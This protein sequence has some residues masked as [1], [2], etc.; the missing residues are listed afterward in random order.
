MRHDEAAEDED[1]VVRWTELR[2]N[3]VGTVRDAVCDRLAGLGLIALLDEAR[4]MVSE[5]VTN[6]LCHGDGPGAVLA[7]NIP[8][9]LVVEVHDASPRW[10]FLPSPTAL[11]QFRTEAVSGRGLPLVTELSRRRC[12]VA[13]LPYGGKSV[14]FALPSGDLL[15]PPLFLA[16]VLATRITARHAALTRR[17]CPPV[18]GDEPLAS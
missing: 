15:P 11:G 6:A 10:P 7:W 2:P 14:W 4:L 18:Q 13:G 12:G 8:Y 3:E 9:G 16:G 5:L 1:A 17:P